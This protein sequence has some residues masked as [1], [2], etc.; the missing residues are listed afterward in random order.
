MLYRPRLL[1][2]RVGR[3]ISYLDVDSDIFGR[4][5]EDMESVQGGWLLHTSHT[6]GQRHVHLQHSQL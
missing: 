6:V 4:V 3:R 2:E 1:W 5:P